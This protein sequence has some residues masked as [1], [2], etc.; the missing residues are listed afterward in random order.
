M[1]AIRM[2]DSSYA[3]LALLPIVAVFLYSQIYNWRYKK[4]SHIPQ[5]LPLSLPLGHLK[6]IAKAYKQLG[7]SRRHS[8]I[9]QHPCPEKPR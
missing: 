9:T 1:I 7:D 2:A 5:Y 3:I 8:S 4:F 6:C